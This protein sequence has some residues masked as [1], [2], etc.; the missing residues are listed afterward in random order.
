[1]RPCLAVLSDF[2]AVAAQLVAQ[3]LNGPLDT[4]EPLLLGAMPGPV[5]RD[6]LRVQQNPTDVTANSPARSL[7]CHALIVAAPAVPVNGCRGLSAPPARVLEAAL[8][9]RLPRPAARPS[10]G[11]VHRARTGS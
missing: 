9:D 7:S 6:F 3:L 2:G 8:R 1:M 11:V 5:H 10:S 4:A